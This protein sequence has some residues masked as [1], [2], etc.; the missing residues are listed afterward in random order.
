MQPQAS[1]VK[2]KPH[3]LATGNVRISLDFLSNKQYTQKYVLPKIYATWWG[4]YLS[5]AKSQSI[6][7]WAKELYSS[8]RFLQI[9]CLWI[10]S[11][12]KYVIQ[13]IHWCSG[14]IKTGKSLNFLM[15]E[16]FV[17]RS[18]LRLVK[19]LKVTF[20]LMWRKAR[21]INIIRTCWK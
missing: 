7:K 17:W 13:F 19:K 8:K 20:I 9:M 16:N 5:S 3:I 6:K 1:T 21:K 4:D 2:V 14:W 10:F 15:A 18:K 12:H 11:V